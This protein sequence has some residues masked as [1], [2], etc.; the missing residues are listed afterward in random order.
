[1]GAAIAAAKLGQSA[2]KYATEREKIN[3]L[4]WGYKA[5]QVKTLQAEQSYNGEVIKLNHATQ[6]NMVQAA[7]YS[8][9]IGSL[10][11]DLQKEQE[12]LK[13]KRAEVAQLLNAPVTY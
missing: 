12:A 1:M 6:K 4:Q 3:G 10:R 11:A 13:L 5:E 8:T 9:Q 7:I 2:V